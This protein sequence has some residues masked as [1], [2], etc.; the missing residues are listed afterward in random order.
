VH[1]TLHHHE[2]AGYALS[3]GL[4]NPEQI[5][6]GGLVIRDLSSHNRVY[7]VA[8]DSGPSWLLKQGHGL[9]GAHTVADEARTYAELQTLEPS[10][11]RHLPTWHGYDEQRGVLALG[12][13]PEARDLRTVHERRRRAPV[14]VARGLGRALGSLHRAT[15]RT[16]EQN[17]R[18]PAPEG[19][20]VHRPGTELLRE[21]SRTAIEVVKILQQTPGFFDRLEELRRQWRARALVHMDIRWEHCLVPARHKDRITLVDWERA[22]IGDPCWDVGSALGHYLNAWICSIPVTGHAPPKRFATLAERPL[23]DLQP[24]MR[25]CWESYL[26]ELQPAAP[27][28]RDWLLRSIR[29]AAARLVLT[30]FESAQTAE[31]LTAPL[32]LQLQLALNILERPLEAAEQLFGLSPETSR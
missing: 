16:T 25:V 1:A 29:Y 26:A 8:S 13:L 7:A 12:L 20:F 4:I 15:L 27:T 2:V 23:A 31:Q 6:T 3:Q 5:V 22:T 24:A 18:L 9:P 21:G 30:A 17:E 32:M 11:T 14:S 10:V 28:V 19:L